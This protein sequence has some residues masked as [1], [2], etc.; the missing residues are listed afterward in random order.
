M[1]RTTYLL[2]RQNLVV[3]R[4]EAHQNV[5]VFFN[6][7]KILGQVQQQYIAES[8]RLRRPVSYE[9][10]VSSCWKIPKVDFSNKKSLLKTEVNALRVQTQV[11]YRVQLP[12]TN[13]FSDTGEILFGG[14]RVVDVYI[15]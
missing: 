6:V 13:P 9:F 10:D 8:V 3:T 4:P 1:T 15:Q 5:A 2:I 12:K 11:S 7:T 14:S